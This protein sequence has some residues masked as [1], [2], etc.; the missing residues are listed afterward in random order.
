MTSEEV[1]RTLWKFKDNGW[2]ENANGFVIGR[3]ATD[4]SRYNI[5][6]KEAVIRVLGDLNI[7]IIFDADFGHISPRMTII[8]GAI[9][10][11]I[12]KEGKG[13]ITFKLI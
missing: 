4:R 3:S 6:F 1:I 9:C 5:S 10:N 7:P 8:N 2:F 12:S 13:E 11:V